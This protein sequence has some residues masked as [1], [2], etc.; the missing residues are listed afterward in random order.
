MIIIVLQIEKQFQIANGRP[1]TL[2]E[3]LQ[4][5]RDDQERDVDAGSNFYY[6]WSEKYQNW[7][8]MYHFSTALQY[9]ITLSNKLSSAVAT[10]LV[11]LGGFL[12]EIKQTII[13]CTPGLQLVDVGASAS[14]FTEEDLFSNTQG[15]CFY[16]WNLDPTWNPNWKNPPPL[17]T[18]LG[19]YF[20]KINATAPQEAANWNQIASSEAEHQLLWIQDLIKSYDAMSKVP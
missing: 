14:A 8:D 17:S 20:T 6:V 16:L 10:G 1:P 9:Q 3:T 19:C 11:C 12:Q 2:V 13:S 5:L 4:L 7:L 15:Q 18:M